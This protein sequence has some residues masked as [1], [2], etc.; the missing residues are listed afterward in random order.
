VR[1]AVLST[2]GAPVDFSASCQLAA[3][4][5]QYFLLVELAGTAPTGRW[6]ALFFRC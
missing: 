2:G 4:A 6:L 3:M 1:V 5:A